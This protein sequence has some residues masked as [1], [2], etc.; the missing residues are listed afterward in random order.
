MKICVAGLW[1]LGVVTAACVASAGHRVVAFD[2]DASVVAGLENG[3]LPVAEPGLAALVRE[4]VAAGSLRF[5]DRLERGAQRCG[6]RVD[7]VRHA[8]RRGRPRGRRRTCW[9]GRETVVAA[10]DPTAAILVSSQLPVGSTRML[11]QASRAGR[12]FA[13][14]PENLRLGDAVA[15]FMQ[16]DRIVVGVRPGRRPRPNRGAPRSLL[17]QDRVDERRVGGARQARHQ[18]LSRAVDRV[19]ERARGHRRA[20][21]RR[22]DRG[23]ARPEDG[24]PDRPTRVPPSR[25]AVRRRHAR[26]RRRLP[27]RDRRARAA[28]RHSSCGRFARATTST[29]SGRGERSSRSSVVGAAGWTVTSSASGGSPTRQGTDTLRRS[30]AVELCAD[31][32]RSGADVKAHD[33]GVRALP[34]DLAGFLTLCETPL[35]AVEGASALVVQTD[36]PV[37]RE[38]E[39]E[40]HRGGDALTDRRRP[41]RLP[42]RRARRGRRTSSTR[43]SGVDAA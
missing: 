4:Q 34:D 28:H 38:V 31:L 9:P 33:S 25:C 6:C 29:S 17:G 5:T 23:R 12:T 8:G 13:Y 26:A 1:H 36:W 40:R 18:R 2:E 21:R 16:P 20:R 22:R 35:E 41:E 43:E 39:P 42:P 11:E 24:A 15:A 3:I 30:G 19:R 37:Y 7:H 27:D 10:A 14:S 32:A